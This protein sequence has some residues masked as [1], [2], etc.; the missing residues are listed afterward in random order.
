MDLA[1]FRRQI[2]FVLS[3]ADGVMVFDWIDNEPKINFEQ[4][5]SGFAI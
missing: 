3:A 1:F 4:L 5:L 2:E